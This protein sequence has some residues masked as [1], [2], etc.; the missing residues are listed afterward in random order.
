MRKVSLLLFLSLLSCKKEEKIISKPIILEVK[1]EKTVAEILSE[2]N[3]KDTIGYLDLSNKK[4]DSL[5]DLSSYKIESLDLS[6]NNL[7]T[8][9]LS[10]LPLTLKKLKCTNNQLNN[11]GVFYSTKALAL[12]KGYNNSAINFEEINLAYNKLKHF[13]YYYFDKKSN[14]R[15]V[16]IANNELIQI[17]I[18][19][20]TLQYIDI[21]NNKTLSNIIDFNLKTDTIIRNNIKNDLPLEL[22][23]PMR[24]FTCENGAKNALKDFN[25]KKYIL[26]LLGQEVNKEF[27]V[28]LA[29]FAK[30]K[31]NIIIG[32]VSCVTFPYWECYHK[33]MRKL[34]LAK[35]GDDIEYKIKDE[36]ILAF[37]GTDSIM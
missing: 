18:G 24:N 9:P 14:L 23:T 5:P 8:I 13:N 4:L 35:F 2:L 37:K 15:K 25:N 17:H 10:R 28:F 1:K 34:I 33:E 27:D 31:Y 29:K 11:F 21:S 12:K 36:A 6:F 30:E 20:K 22:D 32:R 26:E 16:I 3:T 7:D 19:P